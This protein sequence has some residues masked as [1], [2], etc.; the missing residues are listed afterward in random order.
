M[1]NRKKQNA[2]EIMA[3][4]E[5]GPQNQTD[6]SASAAQNQNLGNN[7][8]A[9][10]MQNAPPIKETLYPIIRS[11]SFIRV[12]DGKNGGFT[13]VVTDTQGDKVINQDILDE[14]TARNIGEDAFR[15]YVSHMMFKAPET[16]YHIEWKEDK[17]VWK[18]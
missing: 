8:A 1:S 2:L 5:L 13:T 16:L 6:N 18:S 7:L 4:A 9:A 10:A 3:E 12:T 14:A 17:Y 11:Y 15:G